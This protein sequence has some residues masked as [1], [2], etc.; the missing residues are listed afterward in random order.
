MTN[1]TT[2]TQIKHDQAVSGSLTPEMA[3][4]WLYR[5]KDF[6]T[7]P[8][9][10]SAYHDGDADG[11]KAALRD[12]FAKTHAEPKEREAIRK[13]L[14][15]WFT[16]VDDIDD[17]TIS[18][19]YAFEICF[20]LGLSLDNADD[21]MRSVTGEGIHYRNLEEFI[22]AYALR[23]GM[24]YARMRQL[25][26]QYANEIRAQY[27]REDI[28][29]GYTA[30]GC[31]AVLK[32]DDVEELRDYISEHIDAFSACHNTA[33]GYFVGMMDALQH[34][35]T[36]ASVSELVMQNLYR[37]L[38]SKNGR[39]AKLEK[40]IRSGW[41]EK[42]Q[43][44]KMRARELPVSRKVL[45]L[46]YLASGG[47]ITTWAS[48]PDDSREDDAVLADEPDADFES[49]FI[50]LN[51]MLAECGFATIDPRSP[52]DWMVLF[53]MATGDVF[54]IDQRFEGVLTGMF[55]NESQR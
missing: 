9:R 20:I 41:P 1:Y 46:L 12:G 33:Y 16:R 19:P 26:D 5:S 43:L 11:M 7:L 54:D 30:T 22:I 37:R 24:D 39:H 15:N 35:G 49:M 27:D 17:R 29:E 31:E 8:E 4:D 40:S 53:C 36:D 45:V 3:V 50:D 18:R 51:A 44:S 55:G 28:P 47:G 23:Q 42:T 10:L 14:T 2:L 34:D 52:F 32:I 21:L 48:C 25:R 38:V 6:R 13:N